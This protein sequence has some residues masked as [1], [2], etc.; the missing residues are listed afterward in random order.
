M[1]EEK[2]EVSEKRIKDATRLCIKYI[3]LMNNEEISLIGIDIKS[4]MERLL[5]EGKIK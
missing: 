5:E 4:V 3:P 1:E 2:I